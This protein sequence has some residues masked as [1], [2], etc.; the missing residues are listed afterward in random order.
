MTA[1]QITH[2]ALVKEWSQMVIDCQ[3]SRKT[4]SEWCA[5]NGIK[6]KTYYYRQHQVQNACLARMSVDA[7]A[8]IRS[9]QDAEAIGI[10]FTDIGKSEQ[11]FESSAAH[12]TMITI[13]LNGA[14]IELKNGASSE[15]ISNTFCAIRL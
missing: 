3:C 14:T 9:T 15:L 4:V 8:M 2:N 10:E 11:E 5:E 7:N 6:P 12:A 1:K 13:H